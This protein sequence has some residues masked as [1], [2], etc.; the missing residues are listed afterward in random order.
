MPSY[1]FWIGYLAVHLGRARLGCLG[2]R[3]T[4]FNHASWSIIAWLLSQEAWLSPIGLFGQVAWP[5]RPIQFS[6]LV[7]YFFRSYGVIYFGYLMT[8]LNL[9]CLVDNIS[10]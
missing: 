3:L 4:E 5:C 9:T 7:I 10:S 6:S 1:A 2:K 8:N